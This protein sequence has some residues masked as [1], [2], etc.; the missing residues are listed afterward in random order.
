MLSGVDEEYLSALSPDS[1]GTHWY[2]IKASSE[3]LIPLVQKF[4][5]LY[6]NHIFSRL[7]FLIKFMNSFNYEHDSSGVY[8]RVGKDVYSIGS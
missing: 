6:A 1:A 5:V 2:R 4:G 8:S 3:R 7:A